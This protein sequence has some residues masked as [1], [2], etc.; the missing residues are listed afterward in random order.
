MTTD[1]FPTHTYFE[2]KVPSVTKDRKDIPAN[3]RKGVFNHIL[4]R[5]IMY[6]GGADVIPCKGY[7]LSHDFRIMEE[8]IDIVRTQGENPFDEEDLKYFTKILAQECI[9]INVST[10]HTSSLIS[11]NP[12]EEG[13]LEERVLNPDGTYGV[14]FD[15]TDMNSDEKQFA[16]VDTDQFGFPLGHK[17]TQ[18][19]I[20]RISLEL[21]EKY[22]ESHPSPETDAEND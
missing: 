6:N 8:H 11:V 12:I 17:Y 19:D 22:D 9:M 13:Q 1:I 16:I 7:Y 5:C 3:L 2:F 20:Q 4:R 15:I 14:K 10:G 18:E 21:D